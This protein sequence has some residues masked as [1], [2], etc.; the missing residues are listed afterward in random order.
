MDV[1]EK[2]FV[3]QDVNLFHGV[4]SAHLALIAEVAE[5]VEADAGVV[6]LR[7]GEP[8]ESLYAVISGTVVF[9]AAT[10]PGVDVGQGGNRLVLG[11]LSLLDGAPTVGDWRVVADAR[12]LRISR[13]DLEELLEDAPELA[14]VLLRN[15]AQWVRGAM[16]VTQQLATRA[17]VAPLLPDGVLRSPQPTPSIGGWQ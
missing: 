11:S 13:R 1:I 10:A 8:V 14:A 15:V 5:E 7:A 4:A 12:L 2:V 16:A 9:D 6:L 3:L 17:A